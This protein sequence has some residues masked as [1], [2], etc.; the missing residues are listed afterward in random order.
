M[1]F[2]DRGKT[3]TETY[4]TLRLLGIGEKIIPKRCKNCPKTPCF[5]WTMDLNTTHMLP[6]KQGLIY[7]VID[8]V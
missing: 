1:D 5:K 6:Y 2:V 4:S 7:K 8:K 3:I